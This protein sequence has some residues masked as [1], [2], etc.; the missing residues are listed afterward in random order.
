M[1]MPE[2]ECRT[3]KTG[4]RLTRPNSL[5]F[6]AGFG[7]PTSGEL[8]RPVAVSQART[9]PTF[10]SACARKSACQISLRAGLCTEPPIF[11]SKNPR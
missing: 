5:S 8:Q 2:P 9:L 10:A 4:F 6:G 3:R 1:L 7:F 11:R